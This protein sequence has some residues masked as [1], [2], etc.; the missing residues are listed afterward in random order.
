MDPKRVPSNSAVTQFA[1]ALAQAWT[2]YNNPRFSFQKLIFSNSFS[3]VLYASSMV[4]TLTHKSF[5]LRS[6]V[7]VVVQPDER[8]MYDQ[9]WLSLVLKERYPFDF[10]ILFFSTPQVFLNEV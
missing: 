3:Y 1:D 7:M 9:H 10:I 8:N 4:Y 6:V 5:L 2:E